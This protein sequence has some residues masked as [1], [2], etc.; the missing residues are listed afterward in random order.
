MRRP[1]EALQRS[2]VAQ[3]RLR[4]EPPW[5]FWANTAQRGTRS[6]VEQQILKALGQRAGLPD[7]FVLGPGP[8][9]VGL[10]IKAPPEKLKNGELSQAKPFVSDAQREMHQML[11]KCGVATIIVR[12]VDDAIAALS[13]LGATFRG[14]SR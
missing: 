5:L 14:R 10:E 11:A 4:L 13:T 1:E 12:D 3:L 2:I 6:F 9:L 7:L 8:V